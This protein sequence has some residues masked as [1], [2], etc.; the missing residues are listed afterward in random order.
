MLMLSFAVGCVLVLAGAVA[1]TLL[2]RKIN[3]RP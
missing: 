3:G 1:G 2:S